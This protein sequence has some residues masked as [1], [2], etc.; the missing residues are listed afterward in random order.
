MLG[1]RV[2]IGSFLPGR[3]IFAIHIHGTELFQREV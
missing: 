3:F 1:D 2:R